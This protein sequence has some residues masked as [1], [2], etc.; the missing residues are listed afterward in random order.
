MLKSL[1]LFGFKSFADRTVFDFP[2]G[3]TGVVG[4]NG[5]GKS[6][7][8]DSIKWIL[9]D[10]SAKSLRGK[11]MTD[12][13]FNGSSTRSGAQFA[14]ATLVFDNR[15]RFLPLD[16][17]EVSVGRRLW[18]S[19]DSEYLVNRQTARLKDVR[20]LFVGTGAGAAAWSIIEQ[21][22][23]DQILQSNAANRRLIFEEAAGV[24]RLKQKRSE[25][26]KR[27]ER[28]EQNLSRLAD[29]VQEVET[30]VSSLR[31]QAQ[32]ATKFQAI[33]EE[34]EALRVGL[35]ADDFRRDS[36]QRDRLAAELQEASE[37]LNRVR[38]EQQSAEAELL[39]VDERLAAIDDELRER[40][41]VHSGLSSRMAS[42]ETTLRL[43][44][45]RDVELQADQQRLLRQH[46]VLRQR[47]AEA[48][49]DLRTIRNS[50]DGEQQIFDR[51]RETLAESDGRIAGFQH[52]LQAARE[53]REQRRQE[54]LQQLQENSNAAS[55]LSGLKSQQQQLDDS[56]RE[57]DQ[58]GELLE[59]ELQQTVASTAGLES[60]LLQ[61]QQTLQQEEE[62]A[63]GLLRERE[64]L[65]GERSLGQQ[66]LSE[67]REQRSGLVARRNVLED[68]EDRQEGFGIGVREI[69]R[70]S[71]EA[72]SEPW[73]LILGSVSD[74]L[75]V[76]MAQAALME[77]ALSGRAQLLVV[78]RLQP[79]LEY[80]N[81]GRCRITD[82]VG[83]IS[84]ESTGMVCDPGQVRAELRRSQDAVWTSP[85]VDRLADS[86]DD[87][88]WGRRSGLG[89]AAGA[90]DPGEVR[91]AWADPR[92]DS[93]TVDSV[94][95]RHSGS[96]PQL[97][98][99]PGIVGRADGL[100]RSPQSLPD[101]AARLLADTWVVETLSDAMRWHAAMGG[102]CRF[103]TLQGEL[104][105]AD[106]TLFAGTVRNESALLSRKSELRRLKNELHRLEH[107][108]AQRELLIRTLNLH[109]T[110][111]DDKLTEARTR[112][113]QQVSR[114]REA[115]NAMTEHLRKLQDCE[116]RTRSLARSREELLERVGRLTER[117]A[118]AE[119]R[120]GN[121]DS[122]LAS[123]QQQLGLL[124]QA[125]VD[126]QQEL[127][128]AER[129]RNQAG[130]ELTRAD[131]R[132]AGLRETQERTQ[133]EL[134]QRQLQFQEGERRLLSAAD[135]RRELQL[136][137]LNG[138][139]EFAE[140]CVAEERL[141]AEIHH[142]SAARAELRQH[143][144]SVSSH[145]SEARSLLR[146]HQNRCHEIELQIQ[147]IDL[148]LTAAAERI[149][150]EYQLE[151]RQAVESGRSALAL[152][153]LL[154]RN[155]QQP[156]TDAEADGSVRSA[157]QSE[158]ARYGEQARA[159]LEDPVRFPEFRTAIEARVER[160]RRQLKKVG[161]VGAESLENL[162]ELETRFQ[163][164]DS[165]LKDLD[166]AR[167]ALREIVRKVS[168]ESRRLFLE[169]FE[170]IRGYF[171]ELFRRLFG[172]GEADLVLEDPE[173]VL[174]CSI[175][176]V[177]RPPGKELRS[178]SLLS[179][180]EK[181]LT[182]VALLLSIFRSRSSPFCILDEVDAALDD[183]NIGRFVNVLRDFQVNTQF[184]MIT[185]RKP[186]MAVTD[187]L[188]GVTM[189]ESGISRRLS[190]KFE[191]VDEQ[192]SFIAA[193]RKPRAA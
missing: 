9:G 132:L 175:D 77:V 113:Q 55:E 38:T 146:K 42:A 160:L 85:P 94:F 120:V 126:R 83:F 110:S 20:E 81:S 54:Q 173:D 6:N 178:I 61:A 69:L 187:V 40:E 134:R 58:Q 87:L 189:E 44:A 190:L 97:F 112:V 151:V 98:G 130:L 17:D 147:S 116:R 41:R 100:A 182:A 3:I 141:A 22:R 90:A 95:S 138:S 74:L 16:M 122:Q 91:I 73:N 109:I 51:C 46:G 60:T 33:S 93:A 70:R 31:T 12:V 108:I 104:I 185:H 133:E 117:I 115:E 29:L 84:I 137:R 150:E 89:G 136:N 62:S 71:E 140:L 179:G 80:L 32:R 36:V 72:D 64:K 161:N 99:Q 102:R 191:D 143:R 171:R 176:V 149:R 183:A 111:A 65:I 21:G 78:S 129:E 181:T 13:I 148:Q 114:C 135:R 165:Q 164:L 2:S 56:R 50:L 28:V 121:G 49:A 96:L 45:A 155:D 63:D 188:Y 174:E 37:Q 18:K 27:L 8:V 19:G 53:N 144:L 92:S 118:A 68:L 170:T 162:N 124:Q 156:S 14:E 125:V 186:T 47:V 159:V 123:L 5:S 11:E 163:R 30:Q 66:S 152:W 168:V 35:A 48:E 131:E 158:A 57:L 128:A 79:L 106:G 119:L 184:I 59:Q 101:L 142:V 23:V 10:Q 82:R 139:A 153:L 167:E 193:A 88:Y 169:S 177:A 107:E 43:Q 157:I 4:P 75:D 39:K 24:S 26:L 105:E 103:V 76:D 172:G 145:E 52:R 25:A 1:E 15:S 154:Q 192:G 67:L 127:E 34:L 166:A 7:V 180:G 86:A